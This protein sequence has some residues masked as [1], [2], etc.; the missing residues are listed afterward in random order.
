MTFNFTPDDPRIDQVVDLL[1]G[2][3][4]GLS[5][6]GVVARVPLS[7]RATGEALRAGLATG[8]IA[9]ICASKNTVLWASS[10]HAAK[11]RAKH[12]ALSLAKTRARQRRNRAA[13]LARERNCETPD[14]PVRRVVTDT[15]APVRVAPG[16]VSIF[17]WSQHA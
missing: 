10:V 17:N 1:L 16:P 8:R 14:L 12:E 3:P 9:K 13:Y 6:A 11:L 7:G 5:M 15:W 4:D 2:F